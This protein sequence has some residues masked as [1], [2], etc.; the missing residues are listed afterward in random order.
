MS[1]FLSLEIIFSCSDYLGVCFC[2]Q[3]L[4]YVLTLHLPLCFAESFHFHLKFKRFVNKI[5]HLLYTNKQYKYLLKNYLAYFQHTN[6]KRKE[7][8]K[9]QKIHPQMGFWPTSRLN[10]HWE[11]PCHSTSGV[12]I[13]KMSQAAHLLCGWHF[14]DCNSEFLLIIPG[15]IALLCLWS[16]NKT[17]HLISLTVSPRIV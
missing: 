3:K 7:K 8:Q 14:K 15:W 2:L 17:I 9:K 10:Q 16:L 6:S 1:D 5:S 11:V 12:S 13:G 4:L